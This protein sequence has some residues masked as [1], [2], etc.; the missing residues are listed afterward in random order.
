MTSEFA[1]AINRIPKSGAVSRRWVLVAAQCPDI[2]DDHIELTGTNF[3][4]Q[5]EE[6]RFFPGEYHRDR[7]GAV[8]A[9]TDWGAIGGEPTASAAQAIISKLIK[10]RARLPDE[11]AESAPEA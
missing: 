6:G 10:E 7:D 5:C 1:N 3:Y 2:A 4:I 9:T 8:E 11:I